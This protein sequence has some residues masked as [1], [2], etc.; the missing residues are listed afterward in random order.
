VLFWTK[1]DPDD[2][3]ASPTSKHHRLHFDVG[4]ARL[5]SEATWVQFGAL[6]SGFVCVSGERT[7]V[8]LTYCGSS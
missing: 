4:F 1:K 5:V 2:V 8:V 3:L 7:P 6:I